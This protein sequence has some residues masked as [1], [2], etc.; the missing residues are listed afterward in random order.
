MKVVTKNEGVAIL[1]TDKINFKSKTVTRYKEDHYVMIK[2]SIYQ[3]DTTT[4]N[5]YEE[6]IERIE[7]RNI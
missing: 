5:I 6:N 2:G 4:I 3:E 1:T 7:G